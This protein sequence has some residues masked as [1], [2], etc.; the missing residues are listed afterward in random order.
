MFEGVLY[1]VLGFLASALIALMI[2]PAIWNRAVVLTS[3]TGWHPGVDT[4]A[5]RR[6]RTQTAATA[7]QL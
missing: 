6:P 2:S 1:F 7:H 3:G 5:R 4:V